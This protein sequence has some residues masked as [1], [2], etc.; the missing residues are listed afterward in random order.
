M[1][2]VDQLRSGPA[3]VSGTVRVNEEALTEEA[4]GRMMSLLGP[5]HPTE[6]ERTA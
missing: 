5:D 1:G 3:S 4:V 6:P 2:L